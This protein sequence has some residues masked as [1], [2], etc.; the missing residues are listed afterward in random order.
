MGSKVC[1]TRPT[2]R[3]GA[4]V[5]PDVGSV[6]TVPAEFN[7]I[8]VRAGADL[9][10]EHK[11]VLGL[12]QASHT[13]ICLRPDAKVLEIS[14]VTARCRQNFAD[15]PPVHSDIVVRAIG[16]GRDQ[17][18]ENLVRNCELGFGHFAGG[19]G[20]LAMSGL[21]EA[22]DVPVDAHVVGRVCKGH[23]CSLAFEKCT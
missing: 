9:E 18:V 19:H 16:R 13:A 11:L 21:A 3:V 12:I 1:V 10:H 6:A 17:V 8:D 22:A 20:E 2:E 14:V 7:I 15:M 5:F 4:G 23:L